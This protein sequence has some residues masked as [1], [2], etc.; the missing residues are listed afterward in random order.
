MHAVLGSELRLYCRPAI[1]HM[2]ASLSIIGRTL[3][4]LRVSVQVVFG[5][6]ESEGGWLFYICVCT[7]CR[8]CVKA[9][10]SSALRR[11]LFV[12]SCRLE[13][14][15]ACH[16]TKT[17]ALTLVFLRK[18]CEGFLGQ[19]SCYS[20]SAAFPEQLTKRGKPSRPHQA[21]VVTICRLPYKNRMLSSD[22]SLA[23]TIFLS[24]W[25]VCFFQ[26]PSEHT[27][28]TMLAPF[29]RNLKVPSAFQL[30][31]RGVKCSSCGAAENVWGHCAP[32]AII[33]TMGP[34]HQLAQQQV[35]KRG[36]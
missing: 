1:L 24:P 28:A 6:T 12:V 29:L 25:L 30:A 23:C 21:N 13:T 2:A 3:S 11:D 18:E 17:R 4:G 34:R 20:S 26:C 31:V 19:L 36:K 9:F 10:P 27:P 14:G 7:Y 8:L 35:Q 16:Q 5:C 33:H 15:A 32:V 22:L